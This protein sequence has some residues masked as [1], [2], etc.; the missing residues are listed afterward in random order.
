MGRES[1]QGIGRTAHGVRQLRLGGDFR[2]CTVV[3]KTEQNGLAPDY[4]RQEIGW[5]G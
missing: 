3:I 2:N 5:K 1:S 4:V